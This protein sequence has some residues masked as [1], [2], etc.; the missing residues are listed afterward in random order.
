MNRTW[1]ISCAKAAIWVNIVGLGLALPATGMAK[2]YDYL[3]NALANND[4]YQATLTNVEI[5]EK[6]IN[7]AVA[8]R[9]P[10]VRGN[11]SY[12]LNNI[13]SPQGGNQPRDRDNVELRVTQQLF[14]PGS[15][16][17]VTVTENQLEL[18]RRQAQLMRQQI[19]LATYQAYLQAS[20]AQESLN[21]LDRRRDN[22]EE[23]LKVANSRYEVGEAT[24][25]PILNVKAALANLQADRL[26]ATNDLAA[27]LDNLEHLTGISSIPIRQ[28]IHSP[29]QPRQLLAF[30]LEEAINSP[31]VR[32]N[33][34]EIEIQN[35]VISQLN[36][37]VIPIISATGT[38]DFKGEERVAVEMS[39][40]ILAAAGQPLP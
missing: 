7:I 18:A 2:A 33:A 29:L 1:L 23:Q 9:R 12:Q 5:R 21:L 38:S 22:L 6:G 16:A 25:L 39:V 31:G 24:L 4:Q 11:A 8:A 36:A 13:P 35:A 3:L 20:L 15:K 19:L 40:P 32:I 14:D 28:L 17:E 34:T 27:A 10:Q 26:T 37:T 30:W